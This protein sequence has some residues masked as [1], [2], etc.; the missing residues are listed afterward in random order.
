MHFVL[1]GGP[2]ALLLTSGRPFK[3]VEASH[4]ARPLFDAANSVMKGDARDDNIGGRA[5][6]SW[7]RLPVSIVGAPSFVGALVG[8][9]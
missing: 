6:G 2:A 1:G 3:A 5:V 7:L 9:R 4:F 8:W